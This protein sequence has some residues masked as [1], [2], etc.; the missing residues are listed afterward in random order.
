[1]NLVSIIVPVFNT[2]KYLKE[3]IESILNQTYSNIELILVDDG[4]D[5]S[6]PIICAEFEK[7]DSR[8]KFIKQKREGVSSARNKG[9]I[10]AKGDY[11]C[12]VDSDDYLEQDYIQALYDIIQEESVNIVYCNYKLKYEQSY[13]RKKAR[14]AKGRYRVKDIENKL[15]DD[16]TVTGIL[17]GSV[18]GAIYN[19][20]FIKYNKLL[21]NEKIRR[22]EDGLFNLCA[23]QKCE[24][25]YVTDYEGYI[26][27]QWKQVKKQNIEWDKE[28]D[29][30]TDAICECCDS[31]SNMEEQLRRRHISVIFWNAIKVE[32]MKGSIFSICTRLKEYLQENDFDDDYD[33]LD[34]GRMNKQKKLLIQMLKE[35][36]VF[37]FVFVIRFV[38]PTL[39]RFVKR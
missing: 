1:M 31:I 24:S 15:V 33:Y 3:C 4:S 35:K 7:L 9:I 12:F 28:L 26:Y 29:L 25:I 38:Y 36:H 5:D 23:L 22:N 21:F 37:I 34:F 30:A 11:C 39:K 27:R 16:G 18:C 8:V 32:M 6:S 14:L 13:V 20:D 17:F 19:T 10:S 2:E